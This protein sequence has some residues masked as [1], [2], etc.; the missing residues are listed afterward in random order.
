MLRF[1]QPIPR[2]SPLESQR[3]LYRRHKESTSNYVPNK[4]HGLTACT[5]MYG[6]VAIIPIY[7]TGMMIIR[8]LLSN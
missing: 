3:R 1:H 4:E 5:T 2:L 6:G 7:V 8:Q